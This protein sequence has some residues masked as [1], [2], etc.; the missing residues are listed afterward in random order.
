MN[1]RCGASSRTPAFQAQS[2]EFKPQSHKKKKKQIIDPRLWSLEL[3]DSL[4]D[5]NSMYKI[6]HNKVFFKSEKRRAGSMAQVVKC[7][8]S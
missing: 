6:L 1:W 5:S 2:P 8:P 7:L 3:N 4:C